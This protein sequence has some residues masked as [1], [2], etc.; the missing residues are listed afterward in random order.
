MTTLLS[1]AVGPDSHDFGTT[2][3]T[4]PWGTW[5]VVHVVALV[6]AT[7]GLSGSPGRVA[8]VLPSR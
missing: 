2:F 4:T 8:T 7:V 6:I 5:W 3:T 1:A